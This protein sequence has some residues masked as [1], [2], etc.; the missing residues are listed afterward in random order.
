M[1]GLSQ[2]N[3]VVE[4]NALGVKSPAGG[5]WHYTQLCRGLKQLDLG[6]WRA[7]FGCRRF[8]HAATATA[9]K[10]I[11]RELSKSWL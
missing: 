4:L 2:R 7:S 10:N 6:D 9:V 11:V 3:T 8:S 5:V 1:R